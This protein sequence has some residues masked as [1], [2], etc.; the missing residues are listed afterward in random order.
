MPLRWEFDAY[1]DLQ[2]VF[3]EDFLAEAESP[4]VQ[5]CVWRTLKRIQENPI[6]DDFVTVGGRRWYVVRDGGV[7]PVPEYLLAYTTDPNVLPEELDEVTIGVIRPVLICKASAIEKRA[8]RGSE[9]ERLIVHR[10]ERVRR[11][12]S[13]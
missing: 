7:P 1:S 2:E 11:R 13:H 12:Q 3:Q 8:L 4:A 10:L 9:V 5:E 6:V